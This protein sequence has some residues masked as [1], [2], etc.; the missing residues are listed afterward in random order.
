MI[1]QNVPELKTYI[2]YFLKGQLC[3]NPDIPTEQLSAN[4]AQ[5]FGFENHDVLVYRNEDNGG[6][7]VWVNPWAL[8][9]MNGK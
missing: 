6:H 7:G 9:P 5:T 4:I 3:V 2:E 1:E 8:P